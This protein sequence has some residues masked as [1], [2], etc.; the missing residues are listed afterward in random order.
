VLEGIKI[1][2]PRM[3]KRKKQGLDDGLRGVEITSAEIK[4]VG[5]LYGG[6]RGGPAI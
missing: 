2:L 1:V 3:N 5:L 6:R 4:V